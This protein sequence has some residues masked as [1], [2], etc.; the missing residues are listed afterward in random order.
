MADADTVKEDGVQLFKEVLEDA[1]DGAISIVLL[2]GLSDA[3]KLVSENTELV[4]RKVSRVVIMG[5]VE[6][7]GDEVK[8]D[9]N[10]YILPDKAQNNTFDWAAAQGL[11]AKLQEE[12]IP[13]TVVT[14]WAAY[15]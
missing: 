7:N 12:N 3:W 1:K 13:M 10:G 15:A 6:T 11:Y 14:R 2:S 5:G 9:G 4:R 8:R